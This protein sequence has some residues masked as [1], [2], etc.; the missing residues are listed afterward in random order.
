MVPQARH[1]RLPLG[2]GPG[3]PPRAPRRPLNGGTL[4]ALS[5]C[6][7]RRDA[8]PRG[9]VGFSLRALE[10]A[11]ARVDGSAPAEEVRRCRELCAAIVRMLEDAR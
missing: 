6:A 7:S 11:L 1:P 10:P 5:L 8:P 3:R 9:V 4:G 2:A